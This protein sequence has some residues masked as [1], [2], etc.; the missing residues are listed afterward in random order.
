MKQRLDTLLVA[1]GLCETR[2]QAQARIM[3]GEI[4][5]NGR[6]AL[7]AGHQ[8]PVESLIHL[9]EPGNP[10][11]SRGGLKLAGALERF[12]VS[13]KDKICLDIGA[14]TGGFTDCLLT[15]GAQ[16]VYAVDVGRGQLH[17]RLRQ[18]P[19]VVCMEGTNARYLDACQ[20][21]RCVDLVV[22]DVAF[23]SLRLI[24]PAVRRVVTS[25]ADVLALVK[26]QFEAGRHHVEKGGGVIRDP[27]THTQVL[28]QMVAASQALGWRVKELTHSPLLGP[29]GNMEFWLWCDL[30][31]GD[32][33]HPVWDETACKELVTRAHAVLG[34]EG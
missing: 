23:I 26:P 16:K 6:Q 27:R 15:M 20:L 5:V 7:K 3:A 24:L 31:H 21:G 9:K 8:Y 4:Y 14:S 17:W 33:E 12:P 10:Y 34:Q 11:V 18:D 2:T 28:C 22:I 32:D 29:K 25:E 13:V 30:L 1:R 19:R